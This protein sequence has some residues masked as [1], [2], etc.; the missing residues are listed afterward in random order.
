MFL[1]AFSYNSVFF[2]KIADSK[3]KMISWFYWLIENFGQLQPR[4]PLPEWQLCSDTAKKVATA[5]NK[6]NF[7]IIIRILIDNLK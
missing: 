1:I 7:F 4:L 2:I 5:T 3:Y 6:R